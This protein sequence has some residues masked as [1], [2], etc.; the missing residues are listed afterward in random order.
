MKTDPSNRAEMF[1]TSLKIRYVFRLM[2]LG[3]QH[4][5]NKSSWQPWNWTSKE[6]I[7]LT[8]KDSIRFETWDIASHTNEMT[9]ERKVNYLENS[10]VFV[11]KRPRR[12][13][14][15]GW[16]HQKL[17]FK[18]LSLTRLICR[19]T[20]SNLFTKRHYGNDWQKE[21]SCCW[22]PKQM[23]PNRDTVQHK[24]IL[25]IWL[26]GQKRSVNGNQQQN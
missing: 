26:E 15:P 19:L 25:L 6:I 13:M 5:Q 11:T 24:R 21:R 2:N 12:R 9:Y 18:E 8:V 23:E 22:D 4:Y 16:E 20:M 14:E 1:T 17:G 3:K 7:S 10:T